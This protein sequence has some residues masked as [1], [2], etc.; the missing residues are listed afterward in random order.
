MNP[1]RAQT[2]KPQAVATSLLGRP[3]Y[4]PK[5]TDESR[6][7]LEENLARV[8]ADFD[9]E[10]NNPDAI[11]WLGRRTA[12]LGRYREAIA[13]YAEGIRKYPDDSRL[14]R[15]RGHRYLSV[16]EIDPAI[17]DLT[18]AAQLTD[19]RPDEV[20]PDGVPN[21]KNIPVSTLKTNI[22]YHLALAYYLKGDFGDARRA[23]R[24]CLDLSPNDDMV[25]ASSYWLYLSLRRIGQ[26][27]EAARVLSAIRPEMEIIE[28][29]SY[30]DLL[31][32]YKGLK[33]PE[34]VRKSAGAGEVARVTL[35]YGLAAW[36]LVSGEKAQADSIL[37][38]ILESP[39]WPAFGYLAA[40]AELARRPH[41]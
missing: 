33:T 7:R 13:I 22:W 24:T 37:S 19:G 16:R 15:H 11:I 26:V 5:L 27:E 6:A 10:P 31:L 8:Q 20:E 2:D 39:Q 18:K 32:L 38:E 34:E 14:Y 4:P 35:L 1:A 12:Y 41:R 36:R 23:F 17:A 3:L 40:E 29:F 28:N 25:V 9:R 21:A 30:H